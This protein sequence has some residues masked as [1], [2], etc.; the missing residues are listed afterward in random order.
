VEQRLTMRRRTYFRAHWKP[1]AGLL[2][3]WWIPFAAWNYGS[4][5]G[6]VLSGAFMVWV[7]VGM[8]RPVVS[9]RPLV[10]DPLGFSYTPLMGRRRGCR[11]DECSSFDEGPDEV[12]WLEQ[13]P[14]RSPGPDSDWW[15]PTRRP[16]PVGYGGLTGTALA[17]LL[18]REWQ[19][20]CMNKEQWSFMDEWFADDEGTADTDS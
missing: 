19:T 4:T 10:V 12:S 20:Y 15:Q 5:I 13:R 18:N 7:T 2:L 16:I 3:F 8:L 11:W 14:G 6:V 1:L 17:E 9:R